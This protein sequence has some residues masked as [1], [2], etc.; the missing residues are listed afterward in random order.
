MVVQRFS[1]RLG[2]AVRFRLENTSRMTINPEEPVT[3]KLC[4]KSRGG[5][6]RVA[7]SET[8][9]AYQLEEEH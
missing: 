8:A 2:R 3:C 4:E 9:D 5:G 1:L 7:Y 6:Q